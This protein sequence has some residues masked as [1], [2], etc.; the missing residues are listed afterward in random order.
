MSTILSWLASAL[1]PK[2]A[3]KDDLETLSRTQLRRD[4]GEVLHAYT[5]TE[6]Y[7]TIGIGRLID[8]RKGG[9]ISGEEAA[10]LFS[11]DFKSKLAEVRRR[12]PW[13]DSLDV[14]RQGVLLNMA[15]QMGVEGL[16][17]FKNTLAMVEK[18]NYEAAANGML[19][20]LWARQT[21][22]RAKRLSDQMRDGK[23]R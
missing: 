10:Y 21:P 7:L 20:S 9:G 19:S 1:S 16:L 11:N 8:K 5:D 3:P 6:G 14:A 18:G 2:P 22:N 4:E 15:F 12:I 17:G 23:W 13:F